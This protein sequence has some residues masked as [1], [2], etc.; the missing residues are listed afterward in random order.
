MQ[1]I[2]PYMYIYILPYYL[3]TSP[4]LQGETY[5]YILKLLIL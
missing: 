5:V 4:V 2:L 3:R 1:L